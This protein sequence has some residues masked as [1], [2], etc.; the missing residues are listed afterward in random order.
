VVPTVTLKVLFVFVVLAHE[1]RRIV[2]FNVTEHPSAQWTDQQIVEAFPFDTTPR[3][4]LRD[5]DGIYGTAVKRRITSLRINDTVTAPASPWQNAYVERL[6]G[7]VRRERLDHVVV[8]NERHLKHLLFEHATYYHRWRTHRSLNMDSPRT[9]AVQP[10][11]AGA[12]I[13]IPSVGGLH[14]HYPSAAA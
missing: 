11:I 6:I 3:Y 10:A 2:H 4:L 7:S 5:G 1:R 12:V 14:H 13:E 9:R 8:L